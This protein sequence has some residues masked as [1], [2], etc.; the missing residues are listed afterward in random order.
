MQRADM[1]IPGAVA[2]AVLPEPIF[3]FDG[4]MRQ[5]RGVGGYEDLAPPLDAPE[6]AGPGG[7]ITY[8]FTVAEHHTYIADGIRVHNDSWFNGELFGEAAGLQF[9][10]ML[11]RLLAGDDAS[12]FEQIAYQSVL[13]T[14][15]SNLGEVVLGS[16]KQENKGCFPPISTL[17][18]SLTDP[19]ATL[20]P[21]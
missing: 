6:D 20:V 17:K 9:G 14:I 19:S 4:D 2:P 7:Y 13:G 8:N 5:W 18:R 16:I 11:G 3:A 1:S 10:S 12:V 15:S 21:T